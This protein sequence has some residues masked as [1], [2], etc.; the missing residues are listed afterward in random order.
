LELADAGCRIVRLEG[1]APSLARGRLDAVRKRDAAAVSNAVEQTRERLPSGECEDG[2][3][4]AGREREC[5]RGKVP[6]RPST[7][8]SAPRRR[9]NAMPSRPDAVARTRAPRIFANWSARLP[10]PPVAP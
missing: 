9:T 1:D 4:T 2:V 6:R 7:A 8:A 3:D 5:R 10:T